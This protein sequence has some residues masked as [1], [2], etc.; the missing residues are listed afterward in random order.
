MFDVFTLIAKRTV[1]NFRVAFIEKT[2]MS[3]SFA[4]TEHEHYNTYYSNQQCEFCKRMNASEASLALC[5][6]SSRDAGKCAAK[7]QKTMVYHCHAGLTEIVVPIIINGEHIGSVYSGQVLSKKPDEHTLDRLMADFEARGINIAGLREAYN[8]I[9]VVPEWKI[10]LVGTLLSIFV[11]YMVATELNIALEEELLRDKEKLN[12]FKPYVRREIC[13]YIQTNQVDKLSNLYDKLVFVGL[14]KPPN[15]VMLCSI[16]GFDTPCAGQ[17]EQYKARI[18]GV[19]M[20]VIEDSLTNQ[21]EDY[22]VHP[23]GDGVFM[24]LISLGVDSKPVVIRQKLTALADQIRCNLKRKT[25]FTCCMSVGDIVTSTAQLGQ[26]F[27]TVLRAITCARMESIKDKTLHIADFYANNETSAEACYSVEKLSSYVTMGTKEELQRF[28]NVL[29]QPYAQ[30]TGVDLNEMKARVVLTMQ[31]LISAC[32]EQGM[33]I[34]AEFQ[35]NAIR[36]IITKSTVESIL[37]SMFEQS[38]ALMQEV[39]NLHRKQTQY[40][41][42]KAKY[43]IDTHFQDDIRLADIASYVYLTPNYLGTIFKREEGISCVEYLNRTRI[44][45]ARLLLE[46][47]Q[48]PIQ[49][50]SETVGFGD[51]NYFGQ[52]FKKI[53][54]IR[55]RDCRK[56]TQNIL[57]N[58]KEGEQQ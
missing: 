45:Q 54:G 14:K 5:L 42:V 55:P 49:L 36:K 57:N 24:L 58:P 10:N 7:Q 28:L 35:L 41:V 32:A 44:K 33:K 3:L 25:S 26:A 37:H 6:R 20:Q 1:E 48:M 19:T 43:F 29:F 4:D 34:T 39:E 9:P 31:A 8:K 23:I 47:T 52:V 11:D 2:S 56:Q 16:D 21:I 53:T 18:S 40:A 38:N 22:L 51:A 15:T 13:S 27:K 50:I 12:A 17:D 46:T 30:S